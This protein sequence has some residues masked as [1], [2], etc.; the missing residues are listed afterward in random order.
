[1]GKNKVPLEMH[2]PDVHQIEIFQW[3]HLY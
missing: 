2:V 1:V 3:W